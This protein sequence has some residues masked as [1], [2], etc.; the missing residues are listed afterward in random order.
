M[1]TPSSVEQWLWYISSSNYIIYLGGSVAVSTQ[2]RTLFVQVER[3]SPNT[4]EFVGLAVPNDTDEHTLRGEIDEDAGTL[5]LFL[6]EV[7]IGST[8][9]LTLIPSA[10]PFTRMDFT[11]GPATMG[12][13]S[14]MKFSELLLEQDC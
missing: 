13:A 8:V 3:I 5:K 14:L 6:D 11:I 10:A 1:D 9:A 12:G 7:Q 2:V 4:V